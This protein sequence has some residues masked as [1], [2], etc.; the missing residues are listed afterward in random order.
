MTTTTAPAGSITSLR[1]PPNTFGVG[2]GIA[3]LS[4]CW[5]NASR[6]DLVPGFLPDL[7]LILSAVV[8]V[9]TAIGYVR[10]VIT[11]RTL[12]ADLTDPI[13]APFMS[14]I[15]IVPLML[16]TLGLAQRIPGPATVLADVLIALI[17]LHG[18]WFTGQLFYGEYPFTKLHP[19]Y[20]LP[21][22]AGGLVAASA[23]GAVGQHR[24][25]RRSPT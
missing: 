3:G 13:T 1:V 19:G 20:F 22:V 2:L 23:A 8:W 18:S 15:L 11:H 9:A 16:N 10:S 4:Q 12:I 6:Q 7:L 5:I 21:T 24:L 17:V 14:L 25:G